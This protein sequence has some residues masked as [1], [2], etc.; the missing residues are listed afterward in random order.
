M[1]SLSQIRDMYRLQ[2]EAKRVRKQ[3]AAMHI[4]A[5]GPGVKVIVSA[6]QEIIDIQIAPD[7]DRA[8][9][10]AVLKDCLNRAMKK[11]QLIA[12]ERMQGVM[13]EMG[14]GTKGA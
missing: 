7:A 9:L 13:G 5:E 1:T 12:A 3:L 10:P 4:E 11:A 2:K 6:E 8:T 14:M